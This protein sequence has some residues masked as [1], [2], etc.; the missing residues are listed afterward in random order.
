MGDDEAIDEGR[1]RVS[2]W[3]WRAPVLL[4]VA[5]GGF[6]A[7]EA[8]RVHFL[9]RRP[10]PTPRFDPIAP[11]RVGTASDFQDVWDSVAFT[12]TAPAATPGAPGRPDL[13]ALA[14][15][16]P[17]PIIGGLELEGPSASPPLHLAAFSRVCT[18]QGCTVELNTDLAAI[19]F[20]F[21]YDADHPAL[22]CPCH[23]SV[24]D[25]TLAGRAVSGPAVRPLPR[26]ELQP[27]G[28]E[29]WAVGL[30]R[31]GA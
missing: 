19:D 27:R 29:V 1:R 28:E 18:H 21:N 8:L 10:D 24:F 4:A 26:L 22:T 16:L 3:L 25:P 14:V 2:A 31:A 23:L 12:V 13:P 7:Y 17:G 20:G 15:R 6:G 11:R 30:E 9:K 5:G